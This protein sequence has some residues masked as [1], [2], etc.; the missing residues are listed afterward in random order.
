MTPSDI[1]SASSLVERVSDSKPQ[2]ISELFSN[3]APMA[4]ETMSKLGG[5]GWEEL[6]EP[7]IEFEEPKRRK[8]KS[9]MAESDLVVPQ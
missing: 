5:Y 9:Q 7:E 8:S 1:Y 6:L 4:Y 3:W 2:Q